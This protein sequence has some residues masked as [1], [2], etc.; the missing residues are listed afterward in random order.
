MFCLALGTS[1]GGILALMLSSGHSPKHCQD[2]LRWGS[3]HIFGYFPWRMVNPFKAKYSH[4]A[5]EQIMQEYFGERTMMDLEKKCAVVSFR[6]DGR[7]SKTHSFF[8]REG[9]RPA[10]F[11]NMPKASGVVEPDRDL[12]V[13]YSINCMFTEI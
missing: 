2:L 9:W 4:D 11:S 1:V 8:N 6:L 12:M 10:V 7:R 5:K 3:P 13:T